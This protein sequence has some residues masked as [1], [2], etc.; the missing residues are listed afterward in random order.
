M[1]RNRGFTL[2]E[3]MVVV[4]IILIISAIAIP[5][6]LRARVSANEASAVG[7]I[8]AI[9]TA[10]VAYEST[11]PANGYACTLDALGSPGSGASPDSAHAG[12]LDSTLAVQH[13]KSGYLFSISNCDVGEP[14]NLPAQHYSVAATPQSVNRTGIRSFCSDESGVIR[15]APLSSTC[16]NSSPVL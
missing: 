9:N 7:S 14:E 4:A 10:E 6:L 13:T 3:L 15:Y 11:Y 12:L 2:I 8:R 1:R 16:N 5:N